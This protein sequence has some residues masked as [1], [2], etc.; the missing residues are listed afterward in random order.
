MVPPVVSPAP[1]IV[2]ISMPIIPIVLR[3]CQCW[4]EASR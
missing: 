2:D 3:V 1:D 4:V